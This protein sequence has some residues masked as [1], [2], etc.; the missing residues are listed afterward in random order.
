MSRAI[1]TNRIFQPVIESAIQFYLNYGYSTKFY[2]AAEPYFHGPFLPCNRMILSSKSDT[3]S[4]PFQNQRARQDWTRHGMHVQWKCWENSQHVL[5]YH[6][7]PRYCGILIKSQLIYYI[8]HREYEHEID[9][10][11][12]RSKLKWQTIENVDDNV[13]DVS[14]LELQ[15]NKSSCVQNN[16]IFNLNPMVY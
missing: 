2:R 16:Q 14:T 3:V 6:T 9:K 1:T 12:G 13:N 8:N 4:S 10:F 15:L 5:H 7:H 11:L